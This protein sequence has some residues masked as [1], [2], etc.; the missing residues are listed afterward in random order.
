MS[1]HL[2]EAQNQAICAGRTRRQAQLS[3]A[4]SRRRGR[5]RRS[6]GVAGLLAHISELSRAL[7][8]TC[9]CALCVPSARAGWHPRQRLACFR[10]CQR[11]PRPAGAGSH[12]ERRHGHSPVLT[13]CAVWSRRTGDSRDSGQPLVSQQHASW[14]K[15]GHFHL[16]RACYGW[17]GYAAVDCH[18]PRRI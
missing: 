14:P 9:C 12:G 3:P 18:D 13:G 16:F 5:L 1:M 4:Q 10:V 2:P 8:W 15:T 7:P 6:S 11:S 17:R